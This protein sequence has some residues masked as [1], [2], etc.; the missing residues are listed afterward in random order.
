MMNEIRNIVKSIAHISDK[1]IDEIL[2]GIEFKEVS[3]GQCF[4]K[5][6]K[7]EFNEYFILDGICKSFLLSPEGEEVTISFYGA[8]SVLAPFVIRTENGLSNLNFEALT[9]LRIGTIEALKFEKLMIDN[10]EIREFGNI[11][12][13]NELQR[14]VNKEYQMASFTAQQRLLQFRKDFPAY[15][16]YIPHTAIASYLGITNVSLS[17]IRKNLKD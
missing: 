11:V 9:E 14:K 6:G 17:R 12:L 4:I 10:V 13:K 15:E 2:N 7:R 16:N 3:R 8:S 1:A 5:K